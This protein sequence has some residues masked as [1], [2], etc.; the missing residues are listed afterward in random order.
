MAVVPLAALVV[1]A[2]E[3]LVQVAITHPLVRALQLLAAL[4]AMAVQ[5][6]AMAAMAVIVAVV[7]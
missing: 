2:Q 4:A 1:A 3:V 5:V 6:A 7:V